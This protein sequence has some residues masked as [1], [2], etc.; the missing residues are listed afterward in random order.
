MVHARWLPLLL[1]GGIPLLAGACSGG[2]SNPPTP[3]EPAT[4]AKT[5]T[6]VPEAT[7]T[8]T[9][10]SAPS[11]Q[12]MA[13][14]VQLVDVR[15]GAVTTLYESATSAA[16]DA[17]I[18][19]EVVVIYTA[20][21]TLAFH[22]DGAPASAP[23]APPCQPPNAQQPIYCSFSPDGR[24]V[25][26]PVET[27]E[28]TLPS[29]YVVPL[30]D[31]W[32]MEVGTSKT[33]MVQAGLVHC[34]G[35]DARYGPVWSPSSRYVAYAEYGGE[36]RRFLTNVETAAT[37]Q[38][39]TGAEV[40][41]APVWSAQGNIVMYQVADNGTEARLEDLDAGTSSTLPVRWPAA[42][43]ASGTLIYSPAWNAD[44]KAGPQTTTVLDVA[45]G[46]T[47]AQLPGAP[48]PRLA[49]S[50]GTPVGSG[51]NG[52]VAALQGAPGCAGTAIYVGVA[53]SVQCVE[54]GEE[55]RV[56]PDGARVAVAR[57]TGTVDGR[58]LKAA[59]L[60][61]YAVDV[62]TPGGP[63]ATLVTDAVSFQ[64][65]LMVWNATGTQLLVFVAPRTGLYGTRAS[66]GV[67]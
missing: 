14:K 36:G 11:S 5:A 29:G 30:W 43:D 38:I 16:Y 13:S 62:V 57:A 65:P 46:S 44:P 28:K 8:P 51:P 50:K 10:T 67:N 52:L 20:G 40:G 9:P 21:G 17:R 63:T 15:S 6:V 35:C 23:V 32:V 27:G 1:L 33:Q 22:L 47:R 25:T 41:E 49:W 7:P 45:T 37:R 56:S 48:P 59:S 64:P 61:R 34:G 53:S 42:F 18:D 39:G 19:G 24:W 26:Y 54:G 60:T 3:T 66:R 2:D 4:A 31:Q 12:A 58:Y 55:G